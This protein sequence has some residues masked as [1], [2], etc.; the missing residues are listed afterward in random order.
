[1]QTN[2]GMGLE[3]KGAEMGVHTVLRGVRVCLPKMRDWYADRAQ[4]HLKVPD[5]LT[6][7]RLATAQPPRRG[8]KGQRKGLEVKRQRGREGGEQ[9]SAHAGRGARHRE[10]VLWLLPPPTRTKVSRPL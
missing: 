2:G 7:P 6:Q 9:V 10:M 3:G 8:A 5:L 4:G 1:M